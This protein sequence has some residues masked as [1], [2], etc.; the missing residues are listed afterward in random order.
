MWERS[1]RRLRDIELTTRPVDDEVAAAHAERWAELPERVRTPAQMVGR[2]FTG[3]E[4]THGVFPSCDFGCEPCYHGA[5][6]N[7]V[8]IDGSHTIAE[9]DRQMAYLRQRRGP[10]QYAQL[11]GG[12]VSLLPPDAHAEALAVMRRHGRIPMSFTHGDFD[13]D[14]LEAVVLDADGQPRFDSVSFAVHIDSTMRGRRAVRRPA[15][16]AELHDERARIAVMFRRLRER[17]GVRS[18]LAHNMTVTP[19]NVDEIAEVVRVCRRL[20]Y[21]MASFQPAAYVGD[22][23]R[24]GEGYR[25]LTD[26]RVWR[27]IERGVGRRLP[28]RVLQAGDER[29]NRSTWG[30]WVGR[31]YVPVFDDLDPRDLRARDA[32]LQAIPANLRLDTWPVKLARAARSLVRHPTDAIV[33][34][35]WVARFLARAAPGVLDEPER[36]SRPPILATT[37]VMHRFM[38]AAAV[39]RA[40]ELMERGVDAEDA[41]TR[42]TQERLRACAYGMAHP[43]SDRVV[44]ACV[45]HSV[46]DPA[47]N[48]QLIPLLPSRARPRSVN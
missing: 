31:R 44:P 9:V 34:T 25:E 30:V 20:G 26:E 29:C 14:Y 13:D 7:R 3:C 42:A 33:L 23:R 4:A 28:F 48:Q 16:E 47:E 17:H 5:E 43:A 24:W 45:Q 15:N 32:Y 12:E 1:R 38:D 19:D 18:Y 22:E 2:K 35:R 40:W 37:Y 39:R 6:A 10:G 46:L 21:R 8:P 11:I 41:D 36:R 27:E